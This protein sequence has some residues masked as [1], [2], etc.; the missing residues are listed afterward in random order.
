MQNDHGERGTYVK[1]ISSNGSA[2]MV[3]ITI[4]IARPQLINLILEIC[5]KSHKIYNQLHK[6]YKLDN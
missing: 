4:I 1:G 2:A 5:N 6:I 3:S